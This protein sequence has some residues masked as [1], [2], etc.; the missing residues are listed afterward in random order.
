MR[1]RTLNRKKA[2]AISAMVMAFFVILPTVILNSWI[3]SSLRH[4]QNQILEKELLRS[5]YVQL[6]SY[7]LSR[8]QFCELAGLLTSSKKPK[9]ILSIQSDPV[10]KHS[11][12]ESDLILKKYQAGEID[13]DEYFLQ[14]GNV[15][16]KKKEEAAEKVNKLGNN[17]RQLRLMKPL[18]SKFR[19]CL[20]VIQLVGVMLIFLINWWTLRREA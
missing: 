7:H 1:F 8:I 20:P 2:P 14:L 15:S 13:A 10:A 19:L 16:R 11:D 5:Q 4:H 12:P 9:G 6:A 3:E 18:A 17:L